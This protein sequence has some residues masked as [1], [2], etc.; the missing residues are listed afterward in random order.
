MKSNAGDLQHLGSEMPYLLEMGKGDVVGSVTFGLSL[1]YGLK[2]KKKRVMPRRN[3]QKQKMLHRLL[4]KLLQVLP[5]HCIQV[6]VVPFHQSSRGVSQKICIWCLFFWGF[7][8]NDQRNIILTST[9]QSIQIGA[10]HLKPLHG[11]DLANHPDRRHSL[12]STWI[13]K[14]PRSVCKKTVPF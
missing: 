8:L 12:K 13:E 7:F 14:Q 2:E 9:V 5:N 3:K 11:R 4:N 1:I 6:I 10:F